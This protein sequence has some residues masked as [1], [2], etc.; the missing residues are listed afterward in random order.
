MGR[1]G[2][3]DEGNLGKNVGVGQYKGGV[4]GGLSRSRGGV[5]ATLG[6]AGGVVRSG[7]VGI[8]HGGVHVGNCCGGCWE[9]T[10][11]EFGRILWVIGAKPGG[12][13][14]CIL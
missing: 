4:A 12:G 13:L 11:G 9:G 6:K 2:R 14:I 8:P 1:G 10:L 5:V 7:W 3:D